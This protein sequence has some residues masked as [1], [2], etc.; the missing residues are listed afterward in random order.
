MYKIQLDGNGGCSHMDPIELQRWVE[1]LSIRHFPWPFRHR[2]EWNSRLR[3]TAGQYVLN[4]HRIELNPAYL[5]AHGMEIFAKIILHELCHYHLHLQGKGYRH[6]D[7]EF[8]ALLQQ[9][10]GLRYAPPLPDRR[11]RLVYAC[12]RCGLNFIRQ[13]K[14]DVKRFVCGKC[15]GPI[16]LITGER[17][18]EHD[19]KPAGLV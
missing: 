1:E 18:D 13:R 10:G 15:R 2:A 17:K 12:S 19:Q 4:D 6:R 5:E 3:T 8:K 16:H 11:K 7:P 9:V 14:V